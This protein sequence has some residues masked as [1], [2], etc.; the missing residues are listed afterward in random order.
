M[1]SIIKQKERRA[2][3]YAIDCGMNDEQ[4]FQYALFMQDRFPHELD[5]RTYYS[6]VIVER[7]MS[8]SIIANS[9]DDCRAALI[10][11]Y[12]TVIANG[13]LFSNYYNRE[14]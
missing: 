11:A 12:T 8:G 14:D 3:D 5:S 10:N 4:A 13:G 7:F 9:D 6:M 2:Y 1:T